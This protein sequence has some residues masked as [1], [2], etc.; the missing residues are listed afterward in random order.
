MGSCKGA[1][2]ALTAAADAIADVVATRTAL[3]AAAMPL[4]RALLLD[5]KQK[6]FSDRSLERL[7]GAPRGSIRKLRLEHG[8][9]PGYAQIDTLAAEFSASAPSAR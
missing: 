2:P 9:R 4:S 3:R 8:V 6:G 1:E 7:L 5:A